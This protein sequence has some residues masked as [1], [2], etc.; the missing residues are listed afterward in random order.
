M[1]YSEQILEYPNELQPYESKGTYR[2]EVSRAGPS[3]RRHGRGVMEWS[4]GARQE[5][6]WQED[7]RSGKAPRSQQR[8]PPPI[9][10][11]RPRAPGACPLRT[12]TQTVGD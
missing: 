11:S 7:G 8:R 6:E 5:G 9:S 10:A 1:A 12:H 4:D 3:M 2:G